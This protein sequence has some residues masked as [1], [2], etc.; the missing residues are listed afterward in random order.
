MLKIFAEFNEEETYCG[1][2]RVVKVYDDSFETTLDEMI[3][4]DSSESILM[5][6]PNTLMLT[7][8]N[9]LKIPDNIKIRV[10]GG[11]TLRFMLGLR[12][13][14]QTKLWEKVTYSKEELLQIIAAF[15]KVESKIVGTWDQYQKAIY[16]YEYLKK[17]IRFYKSHRIGGIDVFKPL[18]RER[19]LDTLVGLLKK[20]TSDNG[21]SFIYQELLTRQ[22]I[23]CAHISGCYGKKDVCYRSWNIV[24]IAKKSFL[25]DFTNDIREFEQGNDQVTGF[26]L[27]ELD[28]YRPKNNRDLCGLAVNLKKPFVERRLKKIS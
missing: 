23:E 13:P 2:D 10:L 22:K 24:T 25:V 20:I 21:L 19:E 1:Y 11:Y 3:A 4:L 17:N 9:I 7:E 8:E 27:T 6:L 14:N 16:L 18:A 26:G 5:V 12:N 15:E 28:L